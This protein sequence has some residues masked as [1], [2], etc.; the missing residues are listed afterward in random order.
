[1]SII[2]QRVTIDHAESFQFRGDGP[3]F[4]GGVASKEEILFEGRVVER[5]VYAGDGS[6]NLEKLDKNFSLGDIRLW[7]AVVGL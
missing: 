5:S 3:K 4:F 7:P 6:A 1:M 2:R